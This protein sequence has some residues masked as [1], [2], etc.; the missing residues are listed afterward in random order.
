MPEA[1]VHRLEVVEIEDEHR[2]RSERR[3]R[4]T[5]ECVLDPVGEQQPIGQ[6][7]ERV[8]E[9]SVRHGLQGLALRH[10]A[11]ERAHPLDFP[12][13]ARP[14]GQLD[15]ELVPVASQRAE[16]ERPVEHGAIAGAQVPL[17]TARV[18]RS[19]ALRDDRLGERASE[20][21][22]AAPAEELLRLAVPF[23]DGAV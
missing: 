20:R 23:D 18:S 19:V 14:D 4:Q 22:V 12:D 10:V 21:L 3:A 17:D 15:R 2:N 13:G 16:L 6:V 1:V 7:G 9:G 8:V 5:A 11:D